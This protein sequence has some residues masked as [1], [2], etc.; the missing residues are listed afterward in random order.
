MA[1]FYFFHSLNRM[2]VRSRDHST[3]QNFRIRIA[4]VLNHSQGRSYCYRIRSQ[5]SQSQ[6]QRTVDTKSRAFFQI[7]A[8]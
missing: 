5:E 2:I 8:V 6:E 4:S 1:F 7:G 3:V